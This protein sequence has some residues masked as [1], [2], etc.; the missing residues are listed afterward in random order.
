MGTLWMEFWRDWLVV[1]GAVMSR[2]CFAGRGAGHGLLKSGWCLVVALSWL[3][4]TAACCCQEPA[5]QPAAEQ[6]AEAGQQLQS[7]QSE[8][9]G[10]RDRAE[11][12]TAQGRQLL[13]DVQVYEKAAAWMLRFAEFPKASWVGQ[14]QKVLAEG[15]RRAGRLSEGAPD[16]NLRVGT[17]IRGYVS[18]V[19]GSV[20][21]YALTLPEGVDQIR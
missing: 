12:Q 9:V 18:A 10:L 3:S 1:G 5:F 17:T 16:W 8:L 11:L 14:L 21:P 2:A 4:V 20:Q 7:L 19:D 13:A 15:H 6:L